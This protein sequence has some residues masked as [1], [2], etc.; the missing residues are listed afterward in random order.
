MFSC[1]ELQ[2][3]AHPA[4]ALVPSFFCLCHGLI[5]NPIFG[6][7]VVRTGHGTAWTMEGRN[8]PAIATVIGYG[9]YWLSGMIVSELATHRQW[10]PCRVSPRVRVRIR[11]RGTGFNDCTRSNWQCCTRATQTGSGG[12]ENRGKLRCRYPPQSACWSWL[13]WF[14]IF[15]R[16]DPSAANTHISFC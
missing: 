14:V 1:R 9:Y 2:G 6:F 3:K 12:D 8:L 16:P 11:Q 4:G 10:L 5:C 7:A 15:V 13:E